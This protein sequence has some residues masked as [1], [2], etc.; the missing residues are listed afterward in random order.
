MRSFSR[1]EFMTAVGAAAI[2]RG[3]TAG[4]AAAAQPIRFGYAAI[5]WGGRDLD[6]IADI[7]SAGYRGIQIR[8]SILRDFAS[9]PSALRDEL[10]RHKLTFV[11][12]SSGN[13]RIDP[14]VEAGDLATHA[15]NARFVRDA[16]GLFLQIIDERPRRAVTPAD[17][18]RLGRLL[19]ELGKRTADLGVQLAYHHHMN[20]IG[21]PPEAIEQIMEAADRRHVKLLL[22]IAHFQQGGGDP[23]RAVKQYAD[24][25][26]FMHIK[27]VESV[28]EPAG[29]PPRPYRF[30]ELGRGTV[31]VKGVFA[32]LDEVKFRGW[33]VIELDAVPN[34]A[35]TPK[36][37]ALANKRYVE[38]TIG[39]RVS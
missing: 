5:T 18:V 34:A 23:V 4:E 12:L 28:R 30:V 19:T 13:L 20:S 25:L 26:A 36:E 38:E 6:A 15:A 11:A 22:D 31:D 8:S 10:A 17:Y 37:S 14:A 16:G 1:R 39:L 2:A 9:R 29:T 24:R 33:A 32:A 3:F 27:D 35:R 7:A 21:E